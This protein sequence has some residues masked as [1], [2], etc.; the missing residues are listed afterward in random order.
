MT[1]LHARSIAG[2]VLIF[3]GVALLANRFTDV[4]L[5]ESFFLAGT[6]M[7]IG[8]G[9]GYNGLAEKRKSKLIGAGL[10]LVAGALILLVEYGVI[11]SAYLDAAFLWTPA[12]F[13]FGLYF[14]D[15]KQWWA[16]I[17]A[18]ILFSVGTVV[19]LETMWWVDDDWFPTI[20]TGGFALTFAAT[21][22][23]RSALGSQAG[24][25]L[26]PA[27]VFAV[28]SLVTIAEKLEMDDFFLPVLFIL[29]GAFLIVRSYRKSDE[30]AEKNK[31]A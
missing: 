15:R 11:H 10:F 2:L 5:N 26:F 1:Q 21:Y 24:W 14:N 29:L 17:P 12:A 25:L 22:G 28:I 23:A 27:G 16:L 31:P 30:P 4:F 9:M 6:L 7:V 19:F 20:I 3:W 18:G 13:F 8:A